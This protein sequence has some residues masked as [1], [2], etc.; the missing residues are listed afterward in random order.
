MAS[1]RVTVCSGLRDPP[2]LFA[3]AAFVDRSLH[4]GDDQLDAELGDGAVAELD[5][6]VEVVAGVDVHHRE[7]DAC[8]PERPP[9]QV[10][11]DDG[12]LAAGE[13]QHRSLA[14]GDDLAEHGDRFVLQPGGRR[15]RPDRACAST[16]GGDGV[17]G[18]SPHGGSGD[19]GGHDGAA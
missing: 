3:H 6:L 4:R 2:G 10:Q 14:L 5:D 1:S 18:R 11:Q 9:C 19:C 8:R 7:R 15:S 16:P 17:W 13:Q 12:V